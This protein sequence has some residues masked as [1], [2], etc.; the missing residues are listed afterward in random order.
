MTV[1]H[2]GPG[3]ESRKIE[4]VH[5]E[6]PHPSTYLQK[7]LDITVEPFWIFYFLIII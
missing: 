6:I 7:H 1:V 2:V 4:Y 3:V 5:M